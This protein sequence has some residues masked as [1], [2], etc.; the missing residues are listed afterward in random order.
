MLRISSQNFIFKEVGL[1]SQEIVTAALSCLFAVDV[2]DEWKRAKKYIAQTVLPIWLMKCA[3]N[4][5]F[6]FVLCAHLA[7]PNCVAADLL[8][9]I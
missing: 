6:Q 7:F 9:R 2:I 3:A 5:S 4:F 1:C 8:M